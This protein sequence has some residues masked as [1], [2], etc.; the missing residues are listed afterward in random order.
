MNTL[1]RI[2]PVLLICLS[3]FTGRSQTRN[4]SVSLSEDPDSVKFVLH[5][6]TGQSLWLFDS[7]LDP[8]YGDVLF[9]SPYLHRVEKK[10]NRF[11]LSFIP[12][13][14][15]LSL[16]Y[17]DRIVRNR[18]TIS[19]PGQVVYHFRKMAEKDSIEVSIPKKAFFCEE[20][21]IDK[22]L[23]KFHYYDPPRQ[24]KFR[25]ATRRPQQSSR[26]VEFALFQS[27][28]GINENNYYYNW[29]IFDEAVKGYGVLAVTI[30]IDSWSWPDE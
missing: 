8:K 19:Y 4:V 17:S 22:P 2:F 21:V 12:I 25:T 16:N 7:Y 14:P 10:T 15:W 9:Q 1:C 27:L 29:H 3:C 30:D 24:V 6:N 5:N 13:T 11:K 23:A 28:N 20:Y 26:T 18:E